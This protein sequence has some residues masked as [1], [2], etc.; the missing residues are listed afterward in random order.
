MTAVNAPTT[1]LFPLPGH[2]ELARDI[3]A[4]ALRGG[5]MLEPNVL[6]TDP[7]I[8]RRAAAWTAEMLPA[9]TDRLVAAGQDTALATAVSLHSGLP[10][11]T[12]QG[13]TLIEGELHPAESVVLLRTHSGDTVDSLLALSRQRRATVAKLITIVESSP[14]TSEPSGIE[15]QAL[16]CL[17]GGHVEQATVTGGER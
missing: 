4:V 14:K 6:W 9:R 5:L 13:E 7:G 15:T 1:A 17:R 10:F 16:F 3:E 2:V 8:L 12:V 11:T